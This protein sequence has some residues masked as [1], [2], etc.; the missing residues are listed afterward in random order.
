MLLLVP[1]VFAALMIAYAGFWRIHQS[2]RRSESWDEIVA[3]LRPN[4]WSCAK[5][6]WATYRNASVMVQLAD[7]AA[8]HGKD[9]GL[10]EEL[11]ESIRTDAFHIRIGALKAL[12]QHMVSPSMDEQGTSSTT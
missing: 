1:T 7:Y 4:D 9:Q 2:L 10:P 11:L 6:L 12:V 3:R 5:G 8:E